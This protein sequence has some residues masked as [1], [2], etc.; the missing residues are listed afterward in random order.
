MPKD[1][2]NRGNADVR[3]EL[4]PDPAAVIMPATPLVTELPPA[5]T[6]TPPAAEPTPA[7]PPVVELKSPA[8]HARALKGVKT[9]KRAARVNG[10]PEEFELYHWQHAAAEALHGWKQ[11]EHHEAK[12]ILLSF[13]DYKSA[14]LAASAPVTRRLDTKTGEPMKDGDKLRDPVNSHEAA[15][16]GWPV[17]TDYEPHAPALSQHKDKI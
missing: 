6:T 14:L 12:P 9:V 3:E 7:K 1:T 2:P 17:V 15:E 11:H 8:D 16:K 4:P 5:L 10:E 13:D